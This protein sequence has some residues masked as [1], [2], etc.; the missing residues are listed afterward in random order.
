MDISIKVK[1]AKT[2]LANCDLKLKNNKMAI[3]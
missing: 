1:V 2:F 3:S